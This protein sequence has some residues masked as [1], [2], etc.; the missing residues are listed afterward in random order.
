MILL[1]LA[2]GAFFFLLGWVY[3]YRPNLIIALNRV[4]RDVFFNDRSILLQRKKLSIV[5]FCFSL[6]ALY[7]GTTSLMKSYE[8]SGRGSWIVNRKHYLLYNAMQDFTAKRYAESELK[9]T[10][11]LELYPNDPKSLEMIKI[12]ET[13][14]HK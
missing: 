9:Y 10:R 1:K 2:F 7:M 13:Q 5:F 3:L 11:I 6:L 4:A 14:K 12:L 8:Q